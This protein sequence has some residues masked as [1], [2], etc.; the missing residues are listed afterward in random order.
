LQFV[1]RIIVALGRWVDVKGMNENQ[2]GMDEETI[3]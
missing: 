3:E 2:T 1:E